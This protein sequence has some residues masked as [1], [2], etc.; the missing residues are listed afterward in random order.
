[1]D[2]LHWDLH[3]VWMVAYEL[4]KNKKANLEP[5]YN[6]FDSSVKIAEDVTHH[7]VSRLVAVIGG[8]EQRIGTEDAKSAYKSLRKDVGHLWGG[9]LEAV[10]LA[11]LR[12]PQDKR[13]ARKGKKLQK[14]FK[15]FMLE[16]EPRTPEEAEKRMN[17]FHQRLKEI[18][19][20]GE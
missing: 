4:I 5:V 16:D 6:P 9:F 7:A 13:T 18:L 8:I 14:V 17:N 3:P 19:E 11:Y 2:K 10:S 1:M 12:E 20:E 15:Q